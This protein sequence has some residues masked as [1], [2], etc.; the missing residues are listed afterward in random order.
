MTTADELVEKVAK[1]LYEINAAQLDAGDV[2]W[3]KEPPVLR[4]LFEE[5]A[6]AAIAIV[7]E[8]AANAAREHGD[9]FSLNDKVVDDIV[10]DIEALS[11]QVT[12]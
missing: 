11:P 2:D 3:A 7:V 6:R 8:E 4:E 9:A 5:Q 10:A 12:P 1:V